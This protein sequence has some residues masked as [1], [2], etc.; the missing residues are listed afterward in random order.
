M[1][2]AEK[3]KMGVIFF[4]AHPEVQLG[5]ERTINLWIRDQSPG[6][7]LSIHLANLD[8]SLLLGYKL[9]QNWDAS[10]RVVTVVN[11][12]EHI[13]EAQTYLKNLMSTARIPKQCEIL[14]EHCGFNEFL[15]RVPRAD[16][17]IFGLANIV[18]KAFMESVVNETKSSCI[19]VKTS[20]RESAL[21]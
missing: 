8:L 15:G 7:Q 11:T 1:E 20:G 18:N 10:M 21:A 16:L 5:R 3:N 13:Y 12:Q 2:I 4:A 9:L 6:W 19:F 14:V 17:N